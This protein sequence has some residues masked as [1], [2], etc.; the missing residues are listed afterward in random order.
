M[1]LFE[2]LSPS[3]YSRF[4]NSPSFSSDYPGLIHQQFQIVSNPL[5]S[6]YAHLD[7]VGVLAKQI[8]CDA[9]KFATGRRKA[10]G[11]R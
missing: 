3:F 5:I 9:L 6:N 8:R 7:I 11:P 4:N 1:R 2:S 10:L